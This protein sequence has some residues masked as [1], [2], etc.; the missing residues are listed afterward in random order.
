MDDQFPR[1][2]DDVE[3]AV[4]DNELVIFDPRT[5]IVHRITGVAAALWLLSDGTNSLDAIVSE[6]AATLGVDREVIAGQHQSAMASLVDA[7]LMIDPSR[8]SG[9]DDGRAPTPM[10]RPTPRPT[11]VTAPP[12]P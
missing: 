3:V 6:A 1:A 5:D 8:G 2:V 4:F 12:D 9:G 7:G 11:M 10:P